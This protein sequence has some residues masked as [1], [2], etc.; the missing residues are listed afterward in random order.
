[1]DSHLERVRQAIESAV[2]GMGSEQLDRHPRQ[3]KWSPAEVLE[4]LSRTYSGTVKTMQRALESGKADVRPATVKQS[5][6]TALVVGIGHMP[7]GRAAPE[8][9]VPKGVAAEQIVADIRANLGAMEQTIAECEKC[10][11]A[12]KIAMHPILG[13]LT[14]AQWRKFHWVHTRHH[15]RQ[16]E[17]MKRQ[18]GRAAAAR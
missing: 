14:A 8:S 10:F 16:I 3:G 6:A 11:G 7:K 2:A 1:M 17:A 9:T 5:V 13:P 18:M 4:H 15:M 12:G